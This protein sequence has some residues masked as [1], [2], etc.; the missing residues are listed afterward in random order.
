MGCRFMKNFSFD[1]IW[2]IIQELQRW[3]KNFACWFIGKSAVVKY[4][5]LLSQ[6][7]NAT[8]NRV[9]T[10]NILLYPSSWNYKNS[11]YTNV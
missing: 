10:S 5:Q 1:T 11:Q 6:V 3:Y 7:T 9:S 2:N 4:H 8:G